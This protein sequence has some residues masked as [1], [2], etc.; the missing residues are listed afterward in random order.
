MTRSEEGY[1]SRGMEQLEHWVVDGVIDPLEVII[2]SG[3]LLTFHSLR[4]AYDY[5]FDD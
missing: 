2:P 4:V 5:D 3:Y 1:L